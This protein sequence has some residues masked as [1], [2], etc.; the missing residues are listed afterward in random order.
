M[1]C[2]PPTLWSGLLVPFLSGNESL[3]P[4]TRLLGCWWT[5]ADP[6]CSLGAPCEGPWPQG[7]EADLKAL[8]HLGRSG[9][10]VH[11]RAFRDLG[12]C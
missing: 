3:A 9:P 12:G 7:T 1:P 6:S 4:A 10:G 8:S 5:A 2:P 11:S